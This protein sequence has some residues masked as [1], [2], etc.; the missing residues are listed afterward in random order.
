MTVHDI[1][2]MAAKNIFRAR[3]KTALTMLSIAIGILSVVIISSIGE[4]GKNIVGAEID[5]I[6]VSGLTL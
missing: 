4:T 5:R 3:K 2:C 6:G 1:L